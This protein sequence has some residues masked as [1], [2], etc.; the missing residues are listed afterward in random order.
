MNKFQLTV[1]AGAVLNFALLL[2]FPPFDR[3]PLGRGTSTF[4]AFYPLFAAPPTGVINT[5]LLYIEIMVVSLN[6][7]LGW[8]MMQGVPE[9]PV[10]PR[11]RWQSALQWLVIADLLLILLFPPFEVRPLSPLGMNSFDGFRFAPTGSVQQGIFLPLLF[12][13]LLLLAVNAAAFWLAFGMV[14]GG[15]GEI[16][17]AQA[18]ASL[19]PAPVTR[20]APRSFG[21]DGQYGRAKR[22]RRVNQNPGYSGPERRHNKER[23]RSPPRAA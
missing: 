6:A 19:A 21:A 20:P 18:A 10:R 7:A 13:E 3:F 16:R 2:L 14:S 22:D 11:V 9:N 8:L 23:R 17:P 5:G 12:L 4:D 15:A 1:M